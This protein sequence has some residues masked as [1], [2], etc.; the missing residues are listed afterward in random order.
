MGEMGRQTSDETRKVLDRQ[1]WIVL[2]LATVFWIA[3]GYDTF[4]LLITARPTLHDILPPEAL[5]QFSKYLGIL[6]AV[7]VAGW[8]TG[9]ILG[10]WVGDTLG[11]RKTMI[12]GVILYSTATTLSAATSSLIPFALTRFVTGV[13]I[14]A[15][16]GVGTSLLQEVW[17]EKWRTKG[18]GLLQSGFSIGGV[19]VSAVWILVGST[20]GLSWRAMYLFG[21]IPLIILALVH[22][23]IPESTR[24]AKQRSRAA[25]KALFDT[26]SL[27]RN[28]FG[29]LLVS[30]SITGGWWAVASFLPTFVSS[31]VQNPRHAALYA[32]WAGTLYNVGEIAGCIAFGF[33]AESWGRRFCTV[34]YFVG[35]LIVVPIIFRGLD[36]VG[37]VTWAQLVAGYFTGG[38]YSWYTVQTPELFPTR[39][40]ATAISIVFSGSR[41]LA[42]IGSI[43]A[44]SLA[45]ALGGFGK[46]AVY[47][48]P[49]YIIGILAVLWLPETRG[50]GLPD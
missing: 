49:I 28:L 43:V 42:M 10:G 1:A 12:A 9:G 45:A 11:R 50:Q 25:E 41:Y 23:S 32:G 6:V 13:G 47:F 18:A 31:L 20:F 26:P 7:T 17:P 36:T 35:A 46:V 3:D 37:E 39:Y 34:F 16:W 40:R 44:G 22:K 4:V 30:I 8:A 5:P 15:E 48:A 38:P 24:W 33:L 2:M 19:L 27:R 29:A 14:G 21:I